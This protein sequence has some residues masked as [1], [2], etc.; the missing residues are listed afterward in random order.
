MPFPF[1]YLHTFMIQGEEV[2][3][4]QTQHVIDALEQWAH[5][6]GGRHIQ[7]SETGLKF[8]GGMM[9]FLTD[10]RTSTSKRIMVGWNPLI[11]ISIATLKVKRVDRGLAVTCSF[12]YIG[13]LLLTLALFALFVGLRDASGPIILGLQV[14]T[15]L[16][17]S[18]VGVFVAGYFVSAYGVG[19]A[20]ESVCKESLLGSQD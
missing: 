6:A 20:L 3:H 7:K 11:P 8:H 12:Y 17:V 16:A 10:W 9:S 2:G 14:N 1:S 5:D 15:W 4:G 19:G 18:W 13:L